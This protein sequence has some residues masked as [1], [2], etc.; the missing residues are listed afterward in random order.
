M[1]RVFSNTLTYSAALVAA[2]FGPFAFAEASKPT[3][4]VSGLKNPE[5]VCYLADGRLFVTEIGEDGKDG[6]GKVTL[7][8]GDK[9]KPF[10]SGLNDPKGICALKDVLYVTDKTKVMMVNGDG[11]V[12]VFVDTAAFPVPPLYLNDIA[13]EPKAN[14]ILVSDTGDLKGAGGKLFRIDLRTK[15]VDLLAD[16]ES[17]PDLKMPNGVAFDG[18]SFCILSDMKDGSLY[19]INMTNKKATKFAEGMPGADGLIWD[20]FGRFYVTSWTTGK[21]YGI[22]RPGIAPV[23][24]VESGLTAAADGCVSADGKTVL[25]PDMKAGTLTSIPNSIPGYEVDES[26]LEIG[27]EVAFPDLK[28]TGWEP[29]TESGKPNPFRA[30]LLTHAGD[31]SGRIFLATQQGVL[32]A[33][34]PGDKETKIVFDLS[35]KIRYLDRQNEEGLLGLAFH[36]KFKDNGQ[37]F[38]FY[39]DVK[40]KMANVVSRLTLKKGADTIDA[41]SE[42]ELIRIEKPYWNH[43]GGTIAF[44]PDGYLYI[45][46]GDGGLGGDP[47]EN[48]QKTD[49]LL[50]KVLRIDTDHKENGKPYAIPKDNPFIGKAGFAPEIWAYGLRNIWR[51]AFDRETGDLWAGEVG[52]NLFE[53][54]ILITKGGNYGWNLRESYHPFGAKGVDVTDGLIEPIWEYHHDVGASITGGNVYRGKAIPQLQGAYLYADYVSSKFWALRY[55]AKAGR[56]VANHPIKTPA[57]AVMSFGEDEAGEVYVMQLS[58]D[59]KGIYKLVKK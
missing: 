4:L 32:H 33:F 50:G 52:Q 49:T 19:R 6:D 30:I 39:T 45:T 29:E 14:A 12:S 56:V 36:P 25:I 9:L 31:G 23:P 1:V 47:H 35:K 41:A 11:K 48:G 26:P 46:H 57:V 21:V 37:V 22:P 27:F 13:I 15:K 54:I 20:K 42:E 8:E 3:I 38:I 55:D 40:A 51:M 44:G 28:W 16:K 2:F 5:S 58:G 34:K 24:V 43:D 7:I 10:A 18:E 17:I 59:G 53:E